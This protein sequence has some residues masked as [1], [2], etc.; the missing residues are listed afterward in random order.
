MNDDSF[1]RDQAIDD[2]LP[3]D[4]AI[5]KFTH[6]IHGLARRYNFITERIGCCRFEIGINS[7]PKYELLI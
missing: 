7:W 6:L 4:H 2:S 5:Q 1:N 3:T